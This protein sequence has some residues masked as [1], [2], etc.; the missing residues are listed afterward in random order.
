M[1][2]PISILIPLSKA[3]SNLSQF[4]LDGSNKKTWFSFDST[5]VTL[6]KLDSVPNMGEIFEECA[7]IPLEKET[8]QQID[9][10]V[11]ILLLETQL[12]DIQAARSFFKELIGHLPEDVAGI[13]V[14]S[15][16]AAHSKKQLIDLINE[17]STDALV[18]L[19]IQ[20]F[21]SGAFLL[22]QGMDTLG[23]PDIGIS[24]EDPE[25]LREI[26]MTLLAN[27]FEGSGYLETNQKFAM[28]DETIYRLKEQKDW[29]IP[30]GEP[31]H[32][33]IGTLRLIKSL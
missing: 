21:W 24:G 31:G 23:L 19:T 4:E 8:I 30:E 29:G 15:S 3:T 9:Q 7:S 6:I 16:G 25:E 14:Q 17:D 5:P 11:S 26:L 10:H 20:L 28:P 2:N 1:N 13:Y 33:P 27:Y 12:K 18:D 32:N 22:T